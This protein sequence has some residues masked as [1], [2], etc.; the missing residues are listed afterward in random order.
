MTH[1]ESMVQHILWMASMPGA[2]D[3]AREWVKELQ[4]LDPMYA[5]LP[6]LLR[7]AK[8]TASTSPAP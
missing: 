2:A 3:Y 7:E 1:L 4:R 5:E 6:R 8:S